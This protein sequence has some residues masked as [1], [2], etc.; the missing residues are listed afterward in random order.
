MT[1]VK[2][3]KN[4]WKKFNE[5]KKSLRNGIDLFLLFKITLFPKVYSYILFV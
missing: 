5:M 1:L 4:N 2:I 3:I